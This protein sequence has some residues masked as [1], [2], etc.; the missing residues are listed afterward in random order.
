MVHARDVARGMSTVSINQSRITWGLE[1]GSHHLRVTRTAEARTFAPLT[2]MRRASR[3]ASG[4]VWPIAI[5]TFAS[6]SAFGLL[7]FGAIAAVPMLPHRGY[8]LSIPIPPRARSDIGGLHHRKLKI[9]ALLRRPIAAALASGT[10]FAATDELY[11][12]KAMRSGDFQEWSEPDGERRFLSVGPERIDEKGRCRDLVLLVRNR[13]GESQTH[14]GWRCMANSA[15]RVVNRSSFDALDAPASASSP[16]KGD[17]DL[18]PAIPYS[19]DN[20]L[21]AS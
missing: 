3:R 6:V 9:A 4:N 8:A 13:D 15:G 21:T 19:S 11:V 1:I 7:V 10:P 17:A 16:P 12:V 2:D 20:T 18:A 14:N 5:G